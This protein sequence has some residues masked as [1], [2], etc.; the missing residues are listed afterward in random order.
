M[1]R[2]LPRVVVSVLNWNTPALTLRCLRSLA[3][4][5][6]P[7]LRV[8][9]V[10]NASSDDSVAQIRRAWPRLELI[11]ADGNRGYAGGHEL[12]LRRAQQYAA[13]ALCPVNSD[14][15]VEAGALTALVRAWQQHGDA[16]YGALPLRT[17]RDGRCR[18]NFPDKYLD[19]AGRPQPFRRDRASVCDAHAPAQLPRRVGAVSGSCLLLPLR[20]VAQHGWLDPAWFLYCEEIDYAYRL[21]RAGVACLLVPQARCWHDGGGSAVTS[22]RVADVVAYYRTRNEIE[23][24][25]RYGGAGTAALVALKKALRVLCL[26]ARR[27]RRAVCAGRGLA[28]ALRGRFG[29]RL[30]PEQALRATSQRP[31]AAWRVAGWRIAHRIDLRWQRWTGRAAGCRR[32][33][34]GTATLSVPTAVPA[35]LAAYLSYCAGLLREELRRRPRPLQ[36]AFDG[37]PVSAPGL[38]RIDIQWEHT[39]VAPGGRDSADS[40]AGAVALADGSGHYRVRVARSAQLQQQ[41]LVIEYSRANLANLARSG[42]HV[43]LLRKLL[44]LAPLLHATDFSVHARPRA[45]ICLFGDPRQPRRARLLAQARARDLP[46]QHVDGIFASARLQAL[47]RSTRVLLN[48]HQT[49]HHHTLE[50]LRVLPALQ[51]GVIVVSEN[52]GLREAVPYHE[53]VIWADYADLL[54]TAQRVLGNYAAEHAR[55]FGD[56]RLAQ[57]LEDMADANRA[58]VAAALARL[59]AEPAAGAAA[60]SG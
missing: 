55:L 24:A 10:D 31:P 17:A 51:S 35:Y 23:L 44:L 18:V 30:A 49:D 7:A 6:Y 14:A 48:V 4:S 56:G 26:L 5:D 38:R 3:V 36:L 37:C 22:A 45:L 52:V 58:G 53:F 47:Y 2:P 50:E 27:P 33:L 11:V 13:D 57:I 20:L 25:R 43:E 1:S 28:D 40:I 8:I 15:E 29:K 34:L 39:L 54:D 59:D 41:D 46:L 60:S 12:S 32:E 16:L 19:P 21:R 42:R 9:V